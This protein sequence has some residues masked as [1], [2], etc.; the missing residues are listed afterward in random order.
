[1]DILERYRERVAKRLNEYAIVE[2]YRRRRKARLDY[3]DT[4]DQPREKNGQFG[5]VP[6]SEKA[7]NK[8]PKRLAKE[9]NNDYQYTGFRAN[10][11]RHQH[12]SRHGDE[13]PFKGLDEE[14]YEKYAIDFLKQ[15]V[16]GE[17][18]LGFEGVD[19]HTG[20]SYSVRFDAVSG[21]FAKGYHGGEVSTCFLPGYW[22][23]IYD[24]T[25]GHAETE[26]EY[27]WSANM[28]FNAEMLKSQDEMKELKVREA[29]E[30]WNARNKRK[31]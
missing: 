26:E 11:V 27:K 15:K 7:E 24:K 3:N 21:V 14:G 2:A 29:K 16:D 9:R 18:I 5:K 31:E 13:P 28:Y 1:M 23:D 12:F 17:K 25:K 30:E 22:N 19:A 8:E 10:T 6:N 20:K 4:L